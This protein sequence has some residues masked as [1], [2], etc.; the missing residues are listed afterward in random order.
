MQQDISVERVARR[1]VRSCDARL[2]QLGTDSLD[3]YLLHR[4]AH[5][6]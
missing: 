4:R 1:L 5:D 6:P 3:R 2:T